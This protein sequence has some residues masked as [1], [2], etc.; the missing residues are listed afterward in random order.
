MAIITPMETAE[1]KNG[2]YNTDGNRREQEPSRGHKFSILENVVLFRD[3]TSATLPRFEVAL[4]GAKPLH[5]AG[6]RP[7]R[8]SNA[9]LGRSLLRKRGLVGACLPQT[10]LLVTVVQD[11]IQKPRPT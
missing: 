3:C 7:G 6:A 9:P 11:P 10:L 2:D 8:R 1:S 4:V 5:L